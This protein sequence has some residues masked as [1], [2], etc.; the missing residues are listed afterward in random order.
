M[1]ASLVQALQ[2]ELKAQILSLNDM[3]RFEQEFRAMQLTI[4][5]WLDNTPSADKLTENRQTLKTLK[6]KLRHTLAD[7]H[8][9][10]EVCT[11]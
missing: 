5:P 7:K 8:D 11:V 1:M 9:A 10:E 6:S 3:Q 2:R 4:E